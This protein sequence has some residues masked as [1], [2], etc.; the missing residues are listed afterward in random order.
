MEA[1]FFETRDSI[2]YRGV[3]MKKKPG[4]FTPRIKRSMRLGRYETSELR[5]AERCIASG[6]RVLDI[7][8][9]VGFLSTKIAQ[10]KDVAEV[11]SIEANPTLIDVILSTFKENGVVEKTKCRHGVLEHN[12]DRRS[13]D[14]FVRKNFWAS[15]LSAGERGYSEKVDVPVLDIRQVFSDFAP[16]M[17]ICD[18]EGAEVNLFRE[19]D[20]NTVSRIVVEVHPGIYGAGGLLSF[21]RDMTEQ[22]FVMDIKAPRAADVLSFE[23]A[24]QR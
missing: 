7:G 10:R 5:L 1:E 13:I 16:T 11:L 15:S 9:G 24:A 12:S 3:T 4:V 2:T 19:V 21:F 20:M 22:G 14:F 18:I 6:D 8:A 17:I 23:R